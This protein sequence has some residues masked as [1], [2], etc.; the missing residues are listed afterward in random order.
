[1]SNSELQKFQAEYSKFIENLAQ[2]HNYNIVMARTP[3]NIEVVRRVK[4]ALR[5]IHKSTASMKRLAKLVYKEG[6]VNQAELMKKIREERALKKLQ[7]KKRN[8]NNT[9]NKRSI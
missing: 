2:L 9:A 5:N 7:G 1:M 3:Y 8:V 6:R 4:E